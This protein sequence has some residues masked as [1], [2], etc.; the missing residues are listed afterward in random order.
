[1]KTNYKHT[2]SSFRKLLTSCSA[3]VVILLLSTCESATHI[4]IDAAIND[5][6]E[7]RLNNFRE[8]RR[9]RCLERVYDEAGQ[10]ADSII[11]LEARQRKDTLDRPPRP[12]RPEKPDLKTLEDSLEL[13]PIFQLDTPA[14]A[15]KKRV[16]G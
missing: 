14:V 11:M 5:E 9:E 2:K 13:A 3:L 7:K 16:I 6:V 4:D 1:M 8:A 12:L 15:P 10:I